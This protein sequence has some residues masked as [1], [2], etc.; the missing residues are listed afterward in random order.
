L[1]DLN[2]L[3]SRIHARRVE[4]CVFGQGYVGLS[5]AAAA[6][7]AGMAVHGVDRDGERIAG[8]SAGRLVVPGVNEGAYAL[9]MDSGNLSFSTDPAAATSADVVVICVP[10]PVGEHPPDR[11][12]V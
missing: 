3:L 1:M 9:A 2:T 7:K 10:T 6:A 5:L 11:V 12:G 4:V 8:L